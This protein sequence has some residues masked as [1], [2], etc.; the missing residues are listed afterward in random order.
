MRT[1]VSDT[2]C[3]IDLRKADLLEPLLRL[4]HRFVMPDALFKNE[5]LSL[6]QEENRRYANWALMCAPSPARSSSARP[7]TLISMHDSR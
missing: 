7:G 5:R 3:M 6:G 1:V 4:P 2:S